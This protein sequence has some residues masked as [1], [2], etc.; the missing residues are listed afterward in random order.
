MF[1]FY[2]ILFIL[3]YYILL[4]HSNTLF[5]FHFSTHPSASVTV[6][7]INFEQE[8]KP[9]IYFLPLNLTELK[10]R[11]CVCSGYEIYILRSIGQESKRMGVRDRS[12]SR[13]TSGAMWPLPFLPFLL[14]KAVT[15]KGQYKCEGKRILSAY[16]FHKGQWEFCLDMI[17]E[18]MEIYIHSSYPFP[19]YSHTCHVF[20]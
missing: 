6:R 13:N 2:L 4:P 8:N 19:S 1:Q 18:V 11:V 10:N 16:I 15:L 5:F 3:K 12:G 7:S 17:T 14:P 20:R 9:L